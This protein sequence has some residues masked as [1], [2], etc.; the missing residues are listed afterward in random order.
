MGWKSPKHLNK[1]FSLYL[2]FNFTLIL[3]TTLNF[4]CCPL[5]SKVEEQHSSK[6]IRADNKFKR[7]NMK[8][9]IGDKLNENNEPVL[10][11]SQMKPINV[12]RI[13]TKSPFIQE[14]IKTE[15]TPEPVPVPIQNTLENLPEKPSVGK[16]V[17]LKWDDKKWYNGEI[18]KLLKGGL[19][20]V[21]YEDGDIQNHRLLDKSKGIFWKFI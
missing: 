3:F 12:K 18:I 21:K 5:P 7:L 14:H 20:T 13:I 6:T 4:Y 17:S 10:I 9:G 15:L 2:E 11:N 19:V 8:S 1:L 16:K